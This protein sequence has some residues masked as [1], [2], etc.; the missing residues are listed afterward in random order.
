[1]I[2]LAGVRK[3]FGSK[4]VLDGLDLEVRLGETLAVIGQSGS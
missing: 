3:S 2:R 1:M 4:V